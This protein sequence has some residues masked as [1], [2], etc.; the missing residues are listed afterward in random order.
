MGY[1]GVA[2][3][4]PA[5]LSMAGFFYEYAQDGITAFAGGGKTNATQLKGQTCRVTTVATS[6]DSVLL[7]AAIQGLELVLVN[8]GANPMQV[9]GQGTDTINSVATGTGVTQM[10]N[11]IVIYTAPANGVWY[12]EGLGGG[13]ASSFPTVSAVNGLTAK[14]G[15]GQSGATAITSVIN[16]FTTVGTAA[17]SALLPSAAVGMQVTVVNAAA[18]NSMNVFPATGEVI[19]ALAANTA[20]AV[21]AGKTCTFYCANA[22]QWH[23]VLSA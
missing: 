5:S 8:T 4:S 6:G 20:F 7:P 3:D 9:F 11:S 14:A 23:T 16:R 2:T 22:G 10:Q 15:G 13:F 18:A 1:T 21:A 19:N 17:D 12:A